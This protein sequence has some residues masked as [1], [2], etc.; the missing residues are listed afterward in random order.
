M[1]IPGC[2]VIK[3]LQAYNI[4]PIG[5]L[6]IGA[7]ECEELG[8]YTQTM[9]I[10]QESIIWIEAQKVKVEEAKHK[11]IHGM[12]EALITDT[13]N[14]DVTLNITNNVQSSSIF[15]MKTHVIEH[16]YV[17]YIGQSHHKSITID[18]F[19][20]KQCI[21]PEL[22]DFWN[23]DIQGAELLALRGGAES[24]K[25]C[26]AIY[27]EV[28]TEELYE[29]CARMHEIDAFLKKH[30]FIRTI[31]VMTPHGWGDALYIRDQPSYP[32]ILEGSSSGLGDR[33][34]DMI[35]AKVIAYHLKLSLQVIWD[36]SNLQYMDGLGGKHLIKRHYNYKEFMNLDSWNVCMKSQPQPHT[37]PNVHL[38]VLP[39]LGASGHVLYAKELLDI[40]QCFLSVDR[41]AQDYKNEA[42]KIKPTDA[43]SKKIPTIL[44]SCV[45]IHLR[46]SD[47]I[48]STSSSNGNTT[49]IDEYNT[50]MTRILGH[51]K[52]SK[53][54]CFFICGE[55][56]DVVSRLKDTILQINP[57]VTFAEPAYEPDGS[58]INDYIDLFSL[59]KCKYV[60]QGIKHSTFS[61]IASIIGN[62]TTNDLLHIVAPL[63]K[64]KG[65]KFKKC[66]DVHVQKPAILTLQL[67]D[68]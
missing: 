52:M 46:T 56:I 14:N 6:H 51:I 20:K 1:L 5:V 9:N 65:C 31:T 7:H 58:P 60:I 37:H 55:E 42:H 49:G 34:L 26:C 43:V 63:L 50:I 3:I 33:L 61:L 15:Q 54:S 39:T 67:Q 45:G 22:Y 44:T 10:S 16:P 62:H 23:I 66:L 57:L 68:V 32:L 47:K 27:L 21:D 2:K 8:F 35:A 48:T 64:L 13:D 40:K 41:L 19:F 29:G 17:K 11:G 25:S 18:T 53:E 12:Y 38:L 59:S 36:D 28:N 30:G 4:S 24:M